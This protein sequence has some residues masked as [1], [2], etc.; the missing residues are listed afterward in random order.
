MGSNVKWVSSCPE[1]KAWGGGS[2]DDDEDEET[3]QGAW[4]YYPCGPG[5]LILQ[6]SSSVDLRPVADCQ[7]IYALVNFQCALSEEGNSK[8]KLNTSLLARPL[9][10]ASEGDRYEGFTVGDESKVFDGSKTDLSGR[11][12]ATTPLHLKHI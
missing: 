11:A 5:S 3:D 4:G 12:S 1:G 6:V 2:E 7:G 10:S 8:I 9:D